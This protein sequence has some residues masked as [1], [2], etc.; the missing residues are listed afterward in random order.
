MPQRTIDGL[1]N[2][3]IAVNVAVIALFSA[4]FQSAW[5]ILPLSVI[6]AAVG[7]GGM[8]WRWRSG[9]FRD[10]I[11]GMLGGRIITYL[12][13][14]PLALVFQGLL[15]VGAVSLVLSTSP[16]PC[17][18]ADSHR[19]LSLAETAAIGGFITFME[20]ACLYALTLSVYR[21][22]SLARGLRR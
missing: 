6:G 22:L 12:I 16:S 1:R 7:V 10:Y 14:L 21:L 9:P 8:F 5:V 17:L 18:C 20:M 19:L 13:L 3:A 2:R 15:A 4:I 11:A